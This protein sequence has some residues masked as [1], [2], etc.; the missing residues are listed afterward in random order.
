MRYS[1]DLAIWIIVLVLS[2]HWASDSVLAQETAN[3]SGNG[4]L[5]IEKGVVFAAETV[6][7]SFQDE[8]VIA[9]L[10]VRKNQRVGLGQVLGK[11][12]SKIAEI[13]KNNAAIQSQAAL[14]EAQDKGETSLAER[15]VEFAKWEVAQQEILVSKGNANS[16]DSVKKK[17]AVLQAEVNLGL[18]VKAKDQR[19]LKVKLAQEAVKLLQHKV[20]RLSLR[21]PID[22]NVD[23][24]DHQVG[25]WVR[26]GTTILKIVKL[27]EVR[28]DFLVK[29]E[30]IPPNQLVD[31]KIDAI[32]KN[33]ST[34]SPF[35]GRIT[36]F[37][38]EVSS[39][40]EVRVHAVV[41]N[42][43]AVDKLNQ[44]EKGSSKNNDNWL[45]LPGMTVSLRLQKP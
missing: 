43:K 11:L 10:D 5:L 3:E 7:L 36:T 32:V 9:S 28:V 20:E 12:D 35:S 21:S 4:W 37:D 15:V 30:Q 14:M 31:R 19:D 17:L 39:S 29:L 33:G 40:G 13:E 26:P 25:E 8:G 27:D 6:E 23:R 45:L 16:S 1:Q 24:I 42:R 2:I 38:L 41:Q 22:G 18:S 44:N 34:E